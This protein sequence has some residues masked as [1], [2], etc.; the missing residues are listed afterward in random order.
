MFCV[1]VYTI[2]LDFPAGD[3]NNKGNKRKSKDLYT[4]LTALPQKIHICFFRITEG[5][6]IK[7]MRKGNI[8]YAVLWS[9][10]NCFLSAFLTTF[11]NEFLNFDV[12]M[13]AFL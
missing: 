10:K 4:T 6:T 12:L 13:C 5:Q 1:F 9:L 7:N 8:I 11:R 2:T 3:A